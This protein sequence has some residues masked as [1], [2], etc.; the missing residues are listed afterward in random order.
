MTASDLTTKIEALDKA[1]PDAPWE[2]GLQGYGYILD[3][4]DDV[5]FTCENIEDQQGQAIVALRNLAPEIIV[6][7]RE[8]AAE[9]S[10]LQEESRQREKEG[11]VA[12]VTERKAL[13][14]WLVAIK[15]AWRHI[16]GS[17]GWLS[18]VE[19]HDCRCERNRS[20]SDTCACGADAFRRLMEE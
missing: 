17:Q 11:M 19:A 14:D 9:I 5:I 16:T 3:E 10:R 4:H 12:L 18:C 7:L 1:A 15:I 8:Q 20:I 6:A 13:Q 2:Y